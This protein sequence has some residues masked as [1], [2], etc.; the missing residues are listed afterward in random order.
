MFTVNEELDVCS[1]DHQPKLVPCGGQTWDGELYQGLLP[2]LV[3][4]GQ[5]QRHL[6]EK[7][8]TFRS[9]TCTWVMCNP[10]LHSEGGGGSYAE[11]EADQAVGGGHHGEQEPA[12]AIARL[13]RGHDGEILKHRE[14]EE[15]RVRGPEVRAGT[16]TKCR[17]SMK[18]LS[19]IHVLRVVKWNGDGLQE[20]DF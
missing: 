13:E 2:H 7:D 12:L 10:N 8:K 11:S 16:E 6:L 5:K 4:A 3:K 14:R 17:E 1:P 9:P 18:T 15:E 19:K 20:V